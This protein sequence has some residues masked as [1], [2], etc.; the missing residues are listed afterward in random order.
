MKRR[1]FLTAAVAASTAAASAALSAPAVAQGRKRLDMVT[2]W[3]RDLPG[4]GTS[5]ERI[6]SKI[7]EATDGAL[8]IKSHAAGELVAPFESFDA[9]TSG[10]A[11]IYN[12]AEFYW[13]RKSSAYALFTSVPFGMTASE[14]NAWIYHGGGQE[15]WDEL[16]AQFNL[17]PFLSGNSGAQGCGWF[18]KEVRTPED[19]RGLRM[20]MPGLGGDVLARLGVAV[21]NLP[22]GELYGAL[23]SGRL[24][25]VDWAGP[26]NDL[27]L[28]FHRIAKNYYWPGFQEPSAGLCTVFNL[29]VWNGLTA[30]QQRIVRE[31][32]ASEND[33]VYTEILYNNALALDELVN[34]HGVRLR[35]FPD[36]VLVAF[37]IATAEVMEEVSA[38]DAF[39]AKVHESYRASLRATSEGL[40]DTEL[41]YLVRR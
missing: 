41:A 28:G 32:C 10:K 8:D 33:H 36:E 37:R 13:Q 26:W 15:L 14:L 6:A 35:T 27:A 17:K 23:E 19:L 20:R 5:P 39:A 11:D 4:I 9:V 18:K 3:P 40:R 34:R 29:D 38:S 25:A 31:V 16:A 22:G 7:R 12:A 24:D 30:S 2:T 21:E 1:N